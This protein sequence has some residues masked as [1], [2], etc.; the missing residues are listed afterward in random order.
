MR[1]VVPCVVFA[2]LMAVPGVDAQATAEPVLEWEAAETTPP[3]VPIKD[4]LSFEAVV[5]VSCATGSPASPQPWTVGVQ[6]T[7]GEGGEG[8][9]ISVTPATFSVEVDPAAC[10]AGETIGR[11]TV[12]LR[13]TAAHHVPAGSEIPVLL[14]ASES[15]TDQTATATVIVPIGAYFRHQVRFGESVV[16]VA[17]GEI[18][19]LPLEVANFGN[20]AI[21][22]TPS[23]AKESSDSLT[24]TWPED[25][26]AAPNEERTFEVLVATE[27]VG[28]LYENRRD[29]F[30]VN[31]AAA[32]TE[33]PT[34]TADPVQVNTVIQQQGSPALPAPVPVWVLLAVLTLLHFARRRQ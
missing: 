13:L 17:P 32:W 28:G 1:A 31:V 30:I 12:V 18:V 33:D 8:L 5:A 19:K 4:T 9:S 6:A 20:A 29:K 24:P 16:K 11:E 10:A 2:V 15:S 7:P 27:D 23:V 26:V 14:T 21:R 3:I 25:L 22:L 34:E